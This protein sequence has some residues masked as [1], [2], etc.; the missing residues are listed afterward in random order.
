MRRRR[1]LPAINNHHPLRDRAG[2]RSCG[3]LQRAA[4]RLIR[5]EGM[6]PLG[7]LA[8]LTSVCLLSWM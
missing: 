7:R 1:R 4:P 6:R 2:V 3:M 8:R 5:A